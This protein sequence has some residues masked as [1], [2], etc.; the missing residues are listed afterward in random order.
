MRS[1]LSHHPF[2]YALTGGCGV[3]LF[4]RGVWLTTDYLTHVVIASHAAYGS[5]DIGQIPWWDGPVS[6]VI[7]STLLVIAGAFV[8]SLI[9]NEII[10]SGLQTEKT[11]TKKEEKTLRS[12]AVEIKR[13][14]KLLYDVIVRLDAIEHKN[15]EK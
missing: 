5:I 2:L 4:W 11:L 3:V 7:G 15:I 9:G 14:Q 1:W 13:V 10:I 8:S 12:E 6:L